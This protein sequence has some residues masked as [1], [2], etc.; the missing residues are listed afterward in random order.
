MA[1]KLVVP[2]TIAEMQEILNTPARVAEWVQEGQFTDVIDAYREATAPELADQVTD[3]VKAFFEA[4]NVVENKVSDGITAW[5]SEH[6]AVARPALG[7]PGVSAEQA[8]TYNKTAPGAALDDAG[9]VSIGDYAQAVFNKGRRDDPRL[10]KVV[11]VMDAYSATDP[12][13]GGFLIPETF[14]AE[15]FDLVLEMSI[16]RPRASV[17][18]MSSLTQV[19][20]FVDQTTH[21][22]S[23]FGGMSF[24]R[25]KESG[26]VT[27]TE[28]Q[29]GRVQLTA[30]KLMGTGRV[31][32]ELWADAPALATWL[33]AALPRG[34]SFFEDLDYLTGDGA[35]EPLGVQKAGAAITIA[36]ETSQPDATIVVQN[37]L[38]MYSRMLPQSLD[39]AIWVANPTCFPE[40]MTLSI[41]VGTGGSAVSL[42]DITAKPTMTILGRPLILTEKVPAIGAAG[43]VGFYDF[44][45][46][47]IGDRQSIQVES[48]EHSRFANDETELR[49]ILRNDGRPWIQSALT[50]VN[51]STL[52]PF[53]LLGAR[54]T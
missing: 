33:M 29:F 36:E 15:I 18:Q 10:A 8:A 39:Q 41:P 47:L 17:I 52:S 5:M 51:G 40:L 49:T 14:R 26:T 37:I 22:G 46:Y 48:S 38:K 54:T 43:D 11:E 32:N 25:V 50:P 3:Q 35:N 7:T 45:F 13:S 34:I 27:P 19:L 21:V 28:A 20:P 12:A 2:E 31:P 44:G 6:G 1:T 42:V 53:V 9:F 4:T 30:S 24:S 23:V 16:V